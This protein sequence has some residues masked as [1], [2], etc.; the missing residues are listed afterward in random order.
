MAA[1]WPAI[2]ATPDP[3]R[4]RTRTCDAATAAR[5][6]APPVVFCAAAL[7]RARSCAIA[8]K[9]LSACGCAHCTQLLSGGYSTV[10]TWM[11]WTDCEDSPRRLSKILIIVPRL[12]PLSVVMA[13]AASVTTE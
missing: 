2:P 5:A 7:G 10:G 6:G 12:R 11:N 13:L 4:I 3:F 9:S 8:A 1:A